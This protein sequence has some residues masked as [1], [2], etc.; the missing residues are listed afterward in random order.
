MHIYTQHRG[1]HPCRSME[2]HCVAHRDDLGIDD[3]WK[4][5]SLMNK[6]EILL[7]TLYSLFS[8][9]SV[10]KSKFDELANVLEVDSLFQT[11]EWGLLFV[12]LPSCKCMFLELVSIKRVLHKRNSNDPIKKYLSQKLTNLM[13]RVVLNDFAWRYVGRTNSA[14]CLLSA[15]QS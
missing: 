14:L 13:C 10:K 11:F 9:S 6:V 8:R 4:V 7:M 15:K 2:G 12:T 5:V 1:V 3:A